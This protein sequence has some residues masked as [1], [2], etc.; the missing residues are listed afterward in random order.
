MNSEVPDHICNINHSGS[1]GSMEAKLA[2][3]LLEKV[4]KET[5]GKV[6]VTEMVTDDDSTIRSHCKNIN[7]GGKLLDCIPQPLFLADPSHRIK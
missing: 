3:I 1:S 6:Y 2:L 5:A 7:M 4:F